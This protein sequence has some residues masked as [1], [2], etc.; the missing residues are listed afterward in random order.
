M[1]T[2]IR[3]LTLG[4]ILD[5]TAQLYRSNF[6]LFAGIFAGYAGV[7]MVLNLVQLGVTTAM[8][9][10]RMG[11]LGFRV[12]FF[13]AILVKAFVIVACAA[14]CMGA[15][16]RAVAWVHLGQ[17]AS[18][19]A[20]YKSTLPKLGRYV[21]LTAIV[22]FMILWPGLIL[23]TLMFIVI[24][25]TPGLMSGQVD[26]TSQSNIVTT[27]IT[28][29]IVGIFVL[30]W[31]VYAGWMATRYALSVP[32]CVLEN[33]KA[34]AA[35]KRSIQ[36]TKDSRGRIFVLFLLVMV[37]QVGLSVLSQSF[38][39]ILAI[40]HR[41]QLGPVPQAIS[42]IIAFFTNSF[43]GPIYATGLTVF[44]YDQRVRKE[45]FDIEWMMQTA[46]LTALP[47]VAAESP[48]AS[49]LAP[50]DAGSSHG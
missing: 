33:L 45:G 3:P 24:L 29:A 1:D 39:F 15:I 8:G 50:P 16:N 44:Y 47:P 12:V 30:P 35:I 34:R 20:A 40:K 19:A 22:D 41:G 9:A 48:E 5:R 43:L 28:L 13:V 25:R 2:A 26:D 27:G 38:L 31:L 17:P 49:P 32:V 11:G 37:I 18:I 36:L 6:I 7:L 46:G 14:A 23:G 10:G 21:W 4:E 42:Q